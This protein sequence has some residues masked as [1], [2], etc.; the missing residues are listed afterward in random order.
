[1]HQT[2]SK[3]IPVKLI[4]K[5]FRTRKQQVVR[6]CA[7]LRVGEDL[8]KIGLQARQGMQPLRARA[9]E[10]KPEG[11]PI[12]LVAQ[13]EDHGLVENTAVDFLRGDEQGALPCVK[14][15]GRGP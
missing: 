4:D 13:D 6:A 15:K 12:P 3:R 9:V 5:H 10:D 7:Y 11:S 14:K 1:M 2:K 8:R